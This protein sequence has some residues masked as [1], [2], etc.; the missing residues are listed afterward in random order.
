MY[1]LKLNTS[2]ILKKFKIKTI[3]SDKKSKNYIN[4]PLYNQQTGWVDEQGRYQTYRK[5]KNVKRE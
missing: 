4:P 3:K 2:K 5:P 1:K